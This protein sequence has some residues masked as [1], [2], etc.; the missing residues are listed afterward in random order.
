MSF[1]LD[2]SVLSSSGIIPHYTW[3]HEFVLNSSATNGVYIYVLYIYIYIY[4]YICNGNIGNGLEP[5][6]WT[7][8][9]TVHWRIYIYIYIYVYLTHVFIVNWTLSVTHPPIICLAVRRLALLVLGK[10]I[11]FIFS[12]FFKISYN[13]LFRTQAFDSKYLKFFS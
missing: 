7:D 1:Y 3:Y 13:I 11:K 12:F 4:I 10:C 6:D 8:F 5:S 9:D 2:L